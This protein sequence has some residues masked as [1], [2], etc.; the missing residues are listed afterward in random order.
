MTRNEELRNIRL[1]LGITRK[2]MSEHLGITVPRLDWLERKAMDVPLE[3]LQ[4]ARIVHAKVLKIYDV[5]DFKE[6]TNQVSKSKQ[7]H[8]MTD[9]D[10]V[11]RQIANVDRCIELVRRNLGNPDFSL[12]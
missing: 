4:M 10:E 8:V 12:R 9:I 2:E 1:S 3:I 5:N 6:A 7:E 11:N